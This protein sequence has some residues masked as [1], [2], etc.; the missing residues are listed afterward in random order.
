L[1]RREIA[2]VEGIVALPGAVEILQALPPRRYAIVTS[3]TRA[4]AEV[5]L[6]VA[7]LPIPANLVT[8]TSVK[9]GKPDPDPYLMGAQLVGIKPELCVVIEDAPSGVRAGKTAGARVIAVR[10]TA[11]AEELLAAG[12]DWIVNDL[13]DIFPERNLI[14]DGV[15]LRVK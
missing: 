1:E 15:T 4:L 12:A 3:G 10:T 8:A 6:R 11:Y 2:D 7:G 9:R 13:S 14:N 5:R